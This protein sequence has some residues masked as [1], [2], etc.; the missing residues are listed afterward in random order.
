MDISVNGCFFKSSRDFSVDDDIRIQFS[1]YEFDF[2]CLGKVVWQERQQLPG[3]RHQLSMEWGGLEAGLYTMQM[4]L[5]NGKS[6]V[7]QLVKIK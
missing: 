7:R 1:L 2:M 6:V 5:A 4:E 3:G